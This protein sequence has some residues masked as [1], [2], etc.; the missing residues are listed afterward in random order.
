V[1][2]LGTARNGLAD[3]AGGL[4]ARYRNQLGAYY[5]EGSFSA[6]QPDG[7]LQVEEP[8]RKPRIR[9]FR[10]GRDIGNGAGGDVQRLAF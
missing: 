6:G 7:V 1:E 10:A 2:Y 8:G 3:G 5:F 4:I 9:A